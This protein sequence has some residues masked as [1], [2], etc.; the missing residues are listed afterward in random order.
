MEFKIE[1]PWCN[2]HYSVDESLIGQ[3]VECTVCEKEFIVRTPNGPVP[4]STNNKTNHSIHQK[5]RRNVVDLCKSNEERI[6]SYNQLRT[7]LRKT[8]IIFAALVVSLITLGVIYY[9]KSQPEREYKKGIKA[10]NEHRYEDAVKYLQIASNHGNDK[11]QLLL[12]IC[13]FNGDGVKKDPDEAVKWFRRSAEQ[14]NPEGQYKLGLCYLLG[15]GVR[16]RGNEA[17]YWL[18]KAAE[19]GLFEAMEQL[20]DCYLK[21]IGV[22]K[23]Y[24]KADKWLNKQIEN[25][26]N[27]RY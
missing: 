19:Q 24:D 26:R 16:Q 9:I 1:C 13:Y 7:E 23:D 21:G 17:I 11:A 12:G 5:E 8:I 18:E 4:K 22:E 27:T 25:I 2:Q 10:Y 20:S 15:V 3:K 6:P 14:N